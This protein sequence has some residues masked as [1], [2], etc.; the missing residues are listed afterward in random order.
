MLE[1]GITWVECWIKMMVLVSG[2]D[3]QL[4]PWFCSKGRVQHSLAWLFESVYFDFWSVFGPVCRLCFQLEI[5]PSVCQGTTSNG[6]CSCWKKSQML[7]IGRW[8]GFW[9]A[10]SCCCETE[11]AYLWHWW[12]PSWLPPYCLQLFEMLL[13]KHRFWKLQSKALAAMRQ[14]SV[15]PWAENRTLLIASVQRGKQQRKQNGPGEV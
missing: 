15:L 2:T 13:K 5:A 6:V 9:S 1:R 3:S 4:P 8:F 12:P 7:S 11:S 14:R 10:W